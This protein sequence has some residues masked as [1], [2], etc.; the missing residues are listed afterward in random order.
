MVRKLR[1]K[2]PNWPYQQ[3]NKCHSQ[4]A[5]ILK[6]HSLRVLKMNNIYIT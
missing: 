3:N 4:I 6:T 5:L 1:Q 2:S